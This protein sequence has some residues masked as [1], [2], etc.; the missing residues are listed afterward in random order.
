M[1]NSKELRAE[2]IRNGLTQEQVAKILGVTTT[3]LNYKIHNKYEFKTS[4]IKTLIDLLNIKKEDIDK[5][6]F[7]NDVDLGSTIDKAE[8]E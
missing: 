2:F 3:T 7:A 8:G 1:I 6:F 5:I 4:E